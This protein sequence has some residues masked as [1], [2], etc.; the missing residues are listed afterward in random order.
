VR[1]AIIGATGSCG[2][3][4]AAQLLD[5]GILPAE[6]SLYLIGHAGGAHESELWGLR[7]DLLDAFSDHAPR[8]EVG[9]DVAATE[10]EVV[11]MMAGATITKDTSDRALLAATNYRIFSEAAADVA[12]MS[13][14]PTVVVQSNPVELAMELFASAV[15]RHRII[16]AAAWSDSLRFRREI[17]TELG[18]KRPLVD[19]EMWGQHGDHLVPI[20]S[21]VRARGVEQSRID[22]VI[23][24]ATSGRSVSQL[25]DEIASI[26]EHVLKL[27]TRGEVGDA[28]G[29][30]HAQQPDVRAAIK[31]LFTHFTAGRTTELATAHAVADVVSF[32]A[33]GVRATI[34]A[35]VVLDDEWPGLRGP[36]AVP[37]LIEPR[38][39][40]R[41]VSQNITDDEQDALATAMAAVATSNASASDPR[42]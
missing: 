25:P 35:Q 14:E 19:A 9:T 31:P 8:I 37:V 4:V 27:I 21:G 41:V 38:G 20:W 40:S 22:D 23:G 39:W 10:A 17:A 28:Y 2:R 33:G 26:R 32:L 3:Q 6:G 13:D 7:A 5:R 42:T 29:F 16:G 18:I 11:V 34:P 1:L 15:P 24:R 30:I 36:L 12:R